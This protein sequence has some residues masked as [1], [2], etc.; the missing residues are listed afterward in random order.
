VQGRVRADHTSTVN[1]SRSSL[2]TLAIALDARRPQRSSQTPAQFQRRLR[3]SIKKATHRSAGLSRRG[4]SLEA[5]TVDVEAVRAP[6]RHCGLSSSVS[7]K[8]SPGRC[9]NSA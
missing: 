1:P 8:A 6:Q 9:S 4:V 3:K 7:S 2:A 5:R